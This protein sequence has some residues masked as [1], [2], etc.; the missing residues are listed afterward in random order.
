MPQGGT[1]TSHTKVA[2]DF[3]NSLEIGK[4][5]KDFKSNLTKREWFELRKLKNDKNI[6]IKEADKGDAVTIMSTEHYRKMIYD[7]FQRQYNVRKI[8]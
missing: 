4:E 5:N 3:L 2:I 8:K 6:V 1:M 7:H